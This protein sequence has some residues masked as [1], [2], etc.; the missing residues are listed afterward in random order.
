M[1]TPPFVVAGP[2]CV[3]TNSGATWSTNNSPFQDWGALAS[4]ADGGK[5]VAAAAADVNDEVNTGV[6]YTSQS[7]GSPSLNLTSANG[8]LTLS[9]LIPS[10]DFVLQQS[11][12]LFNWQDVSIPPVLNFN[13]LHDEIVLSPTNHTGFYRLKTP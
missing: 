1:A 12:D 4:S 2:I 9:W 10:T 6:I 13:N 5:L 7:I 11:P 3:S 8:G